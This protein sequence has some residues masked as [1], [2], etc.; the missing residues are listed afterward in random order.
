M[1]SSLLYNF[2]S[3]NYK[4]FLRELNMK[5]DKV[6]YEVC[7]YSDKYLNTFFCNN[8]KSTCI[9]SEHTLILIYSGKLIVIDGNKRTPVKKGECVFIRK[10][11]KP[12]MITQDCKGEKFLSISMGFNRS[13]LFQ[14]WRNINK[15]HFSCERNILRKKTI[16]LPQNPYLQSLY[17][18]MIPY[19]QWGVK[20]CEEI[21]KLKLQ[22]AVYCLLETDNKFYFSLFDFKKKSEIDILD[23]LNQNY[24]YDLTVKEMAECTGRSLSTF[25]R[26]FKKLSNLTPHKW[27]SERRLEKAYLKLEKGEDGKDVYADV[28]FKDIRQFKIAFKQKYGFYPIEYLKE[29]KSINNIN[30]NQ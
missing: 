24:M 29:C 8:I 27:I 3:S 1:L 30:N 20:P 15:K 21:L 26:H 25:N 14:V 22:E 6:K 19:F 10:N 17:I 12:L 16:K 13:F 7:N 23:F 9:Y 4:S 5:I 2:V 18:S 28:G 11:T